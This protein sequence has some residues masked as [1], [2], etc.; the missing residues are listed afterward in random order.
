MTISLT[1]VNEAHSVNVALADTTITETSTVDTIVAT[2]AVIDPEGGTI[3]YALSG[4]D[5]AQFSIDSNGTVKL[6][7]LLDY[8]TKT[9]YSVNV[10]T[11]VDGITV[12]EV[13]SLSVA[14]T[15]EAPTLTSNLAAVTFAETSA[16][17]TTVVT[18]LASD[19]EAEFISYSLSGTYAAKFS[20]D[21]NVVVTIASSL[22]YETKN[23]YN[24]TVNASD[25]T[26]N[27]I[28][29]HAISL[30]DVNEAHSVNVSI[31]N[32]ITEAATVDTVVA[33]STVNDPENG[34]ISYSLSGTDS[35]K[36]SIDSNGNVKLASLLDYETKTSYSI[37]VIATVDGITESKSMTLSI[38]DVNEPPTLNSS[39]A[40]TNF[41]ESSAVGTTVATSSS[42]DP[43]SG[44]VTYSLSG[45]DAA[46]FSI[47]S[48]GTV[49][50]A[51][52]LDYETKTSYNVIVNATDGTN[53][54]SSALAISVTD[55]ELENL[56]TAIQNTPFVESNGTNTAVS[57]VSLIANVESEA[58]VFS[59]SGSGSDMFTVNASS[60]AITNNTT[61][62]FEDAKSYNLTLTAT[63][64]SSGDTATSAITVP[65]KNIEELQSNTLRYSAAVSNVSRTGFSATGTRGDG[66]SGTNLGAYQ[67]E[68]IITTAQSTATNKT[69]ADYDNIGSDNVYTPVSIVSGD[70]QESVAVD[71]LDFRYFY[72]L[73]VTSGAGQYQ[74]SPGFQNLDGH[75]K[76]VDA[77]S[78]VVSNIAQSEVLSA[79]RFDSKLFWMTLD[80]DAETIN[81][82]ALQGGGGNID[83]LLVH[84]YH[85]STNLELGGGGR[86]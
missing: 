13:L 78:E 17:G 14:N 71:N 11:T 32:T 2:T 68:Q 60:G 30:T 10:E 23:S 75:Y 58:L 33:S 55:A 50:I 38:A 65:V 56:V 4:T 36:F 42:S 41:I 73:G 53:S 37:N 83:V 44:T 54:V 22:D 52:T 72:P 63:G 5:S 39:L 27:T 66:P 46:K 82:S 25:G 16:V 80:K 43:E 24:I 12:T 51:S 31:S 84:N 70:G 26:N 3:N 67:Q 57:T 34:T 61:L 64:Q 59:L 77:Q 20:I 49:T 40:A 48:N 15:N 1:D 62:D 19:P 86:K 7:S 74:F 21:S 45:T 76:T 85:S 18:A 81:Y 29:T 69:L 6:A 8:E 79:G 35:A 47:A 9:N 28:S